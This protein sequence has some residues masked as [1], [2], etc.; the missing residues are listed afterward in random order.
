MRFTKEKPM[1]NLELAHNCCFIKG[2]E[3][4]YRDFERESDLRH[5]ILHLLMAHAGDDGTYEGDWEFDEAMADA[6]QAGDYDDLRFVLAL[7]YRNMW[8]MA[9]LREKLKMYEDICEDP[10][11]VVELPCRPNDTLYYVDS[12]RKFVDKCVVTELRY[13]WI[14]ENHQGYFII[15]MDGRLSRQIVED[16]I[17][18]IAFWTEGEAEEALRKK[19]Q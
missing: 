11:K 4:W 10:G 18:R 15:R 12:L 3:A 7:M 5:F 17:G 9:E 2:K 6:L 1:S 14:G 19:K 8:A 16:D 13:E